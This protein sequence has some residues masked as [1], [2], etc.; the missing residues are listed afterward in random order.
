MTATQKGFLQFKNER[1]ISLETYRRNGQPVRTPV[2][3][4]E[5]NGTFYVHTDDKTGKVK[6]IKRNGQV[7]IAPSHFRGKLK[8]DY[9]NAKAELMTKPDLVEK[10]H[11]LIYKKYGIQATVTRFFQRFSRSKADDVIIVIRP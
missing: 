5:E 9:I 8:A 7:R 1:V 3:F 10:Y 11:N 4:L 2:W 6:R